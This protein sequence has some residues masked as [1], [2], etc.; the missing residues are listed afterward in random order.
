MQEKGTKKTLLIESGIRVHTTKFKRPKDSMPNSFA[1]K[2]RKHLRGVRLESIDQVGADR[3]IDM[4]FGVGERAHHVII[5]LYAQGNIILTDHEYQILQLLRSHD[6]SDAKVSVGRKFEF[7]ARTSK[8]DTK[9]TIMPAAL[10]ALLAE[11]LRPPQATAAAPGP[12]AG[13]KVE[14]AKQ[15]V[16]VRA[17][18]KA[19]EKKKP[20]EYKF[21]NV[22]LALLKKVARLEEEI[23]RTQKNKATNAHL[24]QVRSKLSKIKKKLGIPPGITAQ[25]IL[26]AKKNNN[27]MTVEEGGLAEDSEEAKKAK[28]ATQAQPT[29]GFKK[30]MK[31]GALKKATVWSILNNE[32]DFGPQVVTHCLNSAGYT[33]ANLTASSL[34]WKNAAND[35]KDFDSVA[36]EKLSEALKPAIELMHTVSDMPLKGYVINRV[37]NVKKDIQGGGGGGKVKLS[38]AQRKAVAIARQ[39]AKE[40][41]KAEKK[42]G[43]PDTGESVEFGAG[44]ENAVGTNEVSAVSGIGNGSENRAEINN[45]RDNKDNKNDSQIHQK[46]DSQVHQKNDQKTAL[47][48]GVYSEFIPVRKI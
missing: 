34:G 36:I 28:E 26:D 39:K 22:D 6:M 16:Q 12:S 47:E 11:K 46:N 3:V 8:A 2:M 45:H 29:K 18:K 37:P 48:N 43:N 44:C 13:A 15:E 38:K 31:K 19:P 27:K 21:N 42:E 40:T 5:E 30:G 14:D 41:E 9:E 33:S 35:A 7:S 10:S 4:Q 24:M 1:T 23:S 17:T 25:F 32:L 20:E